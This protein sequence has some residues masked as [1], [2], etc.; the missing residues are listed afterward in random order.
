MMEPA[1]RYRSHPT[2][3]F[4]CHQHLLSFTEINLGKVQLL[5]ATPYEGPGPYPHAVQLPHCYGYEVG[6]DGHML[7][8]LVLSEASL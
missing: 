6:L 8:E 5:L 3:R 2:Y 7:G 4:S 1:P